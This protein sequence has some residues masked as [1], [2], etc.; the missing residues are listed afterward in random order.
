[1]KFGEE[2]LRIGVRDDRRVFK[3]RP[4]EPIGR[5]TQW[6][7]CA[8]FQLL[9]LGTCIGNPRHILL[10]CHRVYLQGRVGALQFPNEMLH[11]ALTTRDGA[12]MSGETSI[13]REELRK[14]VVHASC[15]ALMLSSAQRCEFPSI[16]SCIFPNLS[17]PFAHAFSQRSQIALIIEMPVHPLIAFIAGQPTRAMSA[18]VGDVERL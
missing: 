9:L 3:E 13:G 1:M 4:H 14:A 15:D 11:A 2:F 6:N 5:H 8:L 18:I 12:G 17:Q 7:A 16:A 10:A